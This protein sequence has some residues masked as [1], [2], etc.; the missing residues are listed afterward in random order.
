MINVDLIENIIVVLIN[1]IGLWMA[2]WVFNADKKEKLNQWFFAMTFFVVLWVD[3]AFLGYKAN[4]IF[5]ATFFYRLNFFAVALFLVS[6]YYFY[7][8]YFLKEKGKHPIFEK[9]VLFA[10]IFLAFLSA[11][12]NFI[13][14]NTIIQPGRTEI[15]FGSANNLFNIYAFIVALIVI[16]LLIK[17]YFKSPV[18]E[19]TK[20][21][22][23]LIGTFLFVLFNIVFNII[24]PSRTGTI[25]YSMFGDYSA[26][27]LL[28][29]TAYAIVKHKLFGIKIILTAFLIILIAILLTLDTLLFTTQIAVQI[30]KAISLFIFLIFGYYLIKSVREEVKR[31]EEAEILSNAKSEFISMASHQLRTPLTAIKGYTSMMLEESYGKIEPRGKRV[32]SNVLISSERLVKIVE[33]LL[34]IS[35]IELGRMKL[36]KQ[37]IDMKKMID[38]VY[39]E[40]KTRAKNK[41][42]NL[43]WKKPKIAFPKLNIDELK[44]RQVIYNIV[45]NA[46]KYTK[47]GKIEIK[48]A[49]E[50][51]NLVI[52]ISD[53]GRGFDKDDK[54]KLFELFTRGKAGTDTFVE[55]TGMGLYIARKFIT[56][57][58]GKIWADSKGKNKGSSFYIELPIK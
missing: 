32:L 21:Q 9:F 31:R 3:F 48:L 13:I 57:H 24:I 20:I 4:E 53:T 46:I 28:C 15:I 34:N 6:F 5:L 37:S 1:L 54:N 27:F 8:V 44:I 10:G 56:L 36:E 45:D 25:A 39:Q 35:R 42:L 50:N 22:Y 14:K 38:G 17:K 51:S 52:S 2:F 19:K 49:R 7:V 43:I 29:F 26:I 23:F 16:G 18:L 30:L 47:T 33:D 58:Q 55:G 41:G 12:T 11:F 40:M